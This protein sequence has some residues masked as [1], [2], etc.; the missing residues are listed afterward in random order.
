MTINLRDELIDSGTYAHLFRALGD[1]NRLRILRHLS[2]G[3]HRVCD[4]VGHLG[5]AQS[6]V[7]AHLACLR[8][9]G[10]VTVRTEGRS[11][12]YALAAGNAVSRVLEAAADLL[13]ATGAHVDDCR[14]LRRET[15]VAD[16]AVARA[17][18][19]DAAAAETRGSGAQ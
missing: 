15:R 11:S 4:L 5:L 6:T 1:V 17:A 8:G 9:C 19:A 10:L 3:E 16:A 12:V 13:T 7:S 2:L 18:D 14:A